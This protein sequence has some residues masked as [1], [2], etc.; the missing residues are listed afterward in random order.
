[1]VK[2]TLALC[3]SFALICVASYALEASNEGG[4]D[5]RDILVEDAEPA[6]GSDDSASITLTRPW[7]QWL[8]SKLNTQAGTLG[9][10]LALLLLAAILAKGYVRSKKAPAS[11]KVSPEDADGKCFGGTCFCAP[12]G[13]CT[14]AVLN[15]SLG[16]LAGASLICYSVAQLM[17]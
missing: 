17:L 10:V 15:A 7:K 5:A 9:L 16:T 6:D 1:M 11:T 8:P 2:T 14:K 13:L 12:N 4:S 3:S